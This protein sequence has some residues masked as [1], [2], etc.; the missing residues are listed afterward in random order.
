MFRN[1]LLPI[2]ASIDGE[3]LSYQDVRF[4]VSLCVSGSGWVG[5]HISR[6]W[7]SGRR[8]IDIDP[9]PWVRGPCLI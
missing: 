3:D 6:W 8:L 2:S 4:L 1:R 5:T 9:A 7:L